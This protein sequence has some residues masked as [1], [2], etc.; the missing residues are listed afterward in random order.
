M[1][2][3]KSVRRSELAAGNL[4]DPYMRS[5]TLYAYVHGAKIETRFF[6]IVCNAFK[7]CQL[8]VSHSKKVIR[9]KYTTVASSVCVCFG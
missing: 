5:M 4:A 6:R 8:V 1:K 7:L 9:V 3:G 2:I